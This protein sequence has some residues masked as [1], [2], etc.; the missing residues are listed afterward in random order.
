MARRYNSGLMVE[1]RGHMTKILA[2][3]SLSN[4]ATGWVLT[5][6]WS[7]AEP[8]TMARARGPRP[9][10]RWEE[11]LPCLHVTEHMAAS[12]VFLPGGEHEGEARGSMGGVGEEGDEELGALW[13]SEIDGVGVPALAA[14]GAGAVCVRRVM[15]VRCVRLG[16]GW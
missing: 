6:S 5:M 11:E 14:L 13:R 7:R 3:P 10:E 15:C 16:F 12:T 8:V 9:H 4:S 1:V 2:W